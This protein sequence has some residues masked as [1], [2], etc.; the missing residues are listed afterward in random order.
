MDG[1]FED[2]SILVDL[3]IVSPF[4]ASLKKTLSVIVDTGCTADLI[5]TYAEAFPLALALVGIENYTIAD[6][7]KVSFFKCLGVVNFAGKTTQ[8]LISIR[9]SGCP[10]MGVSLLKKLGLTLEIDF[11]RQ[12]VF[13]KPSSKK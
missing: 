6:G 12:T 11:P 7:S 13:F 9:P 3:E 5:L 1:R 10:L 8:C 4:S 2:N